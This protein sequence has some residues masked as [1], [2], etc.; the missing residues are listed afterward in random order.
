MHL[1]QLTPITRYAAAALLLAIALV[2]ELI[3]GFRLG[4]AEGNLTEALMGLALIV[5]AVIT[6]AP[7]GR[8]RRFLASA[9]AF[10]AVVLLWSINA[11]FST[12]LDVAYGGAYPWSGTRVFAL[13]VV[14]GPIVGLMAALLTFGFAHLGAFNRPSAGPG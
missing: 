1:N 8:S 14:A 12:S 13:T 9:A 6:L 5:A 11:R 3:L 7:L 2:A 4:E 10:V